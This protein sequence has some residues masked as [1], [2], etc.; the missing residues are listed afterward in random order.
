MST[1]IQSQ[2]VG[3][4]TDLGFEPAPPEPDQQP[5]VGGLYRL[6]ASEKASRFLNPVLAGTAEIVVDSGG[7]IEVQERPTT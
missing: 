2:V 4:L 6:V 3:V 7:T 1:Q 5:V